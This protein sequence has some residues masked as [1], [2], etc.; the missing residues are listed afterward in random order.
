MQ[1]FE[2]SQLSKHDHV[3]S[4]G[5]VSSQ[6]LKICYG[7]KKGFCKRKGRAK[8][9]PVINNPGRFVCLKC[10]DKLVNGGTVEGMTV[11]NESPL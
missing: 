5:A 4:R 10:A 9:A 1:H 6:V 3:L 7:C 8:A 2:H 11:L